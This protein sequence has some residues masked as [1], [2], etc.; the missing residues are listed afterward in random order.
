MSYRLGFDIGGTFTDFVLLDTETG[1]IRI[2]KCLTTPSDPSVGALQGAHRTLEER[3]LTLADIDR[4]IHGT[5][6]VANALIERRGAPTALLTTAGYRDTLEILH[7]ARYD[8]YNY[9]AVFPK[10]LIPRR[11]RLEIDE[12]VLF[13]GTVHRPIDLD[14]VEERIRWALEQGIQSFTVCF[15]HSYANSQHEEAVGALLAERFPEVSATLSSELVREIGEVDRVSTAA[16][17]AFVQ[18]LMKAYLR[19]LEAAFGAPPAGEPAARPDGDVG[20][21]EARTSRLLLMLSSGGTTSVETAEAYPI[22]LVESGPAAGALAAAFYS[23]ICDI[24]NVISFDMGGT[25]AKACLIDDRRPA[26]AN[27]F[28]VAREERFKRGSGLPLKVPVIDLIE[29]GAGGG[30]IAHIDAMGLLKVGPESAGADPGP[31]CYGRGGR[32]PTVTDA[33]L[34]LGYLDAG[35]FL[36][37][38]M[39]LDLEAA[40][41]AI[42]EHLAEPLGIGVVEAAWGIHDIVNENMAGATRTHVAEKNRDPRRYA[43]VAFGGAGA[44]HAC[45]VARK[46]R[47]PR[48]VVP[49]AAGATSALGLLVAPPAFDL[50]QSYVGTLAELDWGRVAGIF[51]DLEQRAA[52]TMARAGIARGQVTFERSVDCR[53]LGQSNQIRVRLPRADFGPSPADEVMALFCR[54]YEQLYSLLNPEYPIEALSWRLRAVGPDQMIRLDSTAGTGAGTGDALH[55]R[56]RVYVRDVGAY[57]DCPVYRHAALTPGTRIDG[58]AIFEQRESTAVVGPGDRVEV[59]RWRNLIVT[60]SQTLTPTPPHPGR[61]TEAR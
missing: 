57:I 3:G 38:E 7:G 56:R 54:Q 51:A 29:I 6:L 34:V 15:L 21:S 35:Y 32:L 12:R 20:A 26:M 41:R 60:L 19:K 46:V 31:A 43:L 23:R 16:A 33:N 37:G 55:G 2:G 30:S 8:L 22:M 27:E 53:Y 36:G 61:E 28:E 10:P 40:E 50:V 58:P 44:A 47:A 25:T 13:D 5:T 49:L 17:N 4:A 42:R 52:A 24:P 9:F 1:Q 59:D 48:V 39:R 11:F 45:S 14:A 18:P